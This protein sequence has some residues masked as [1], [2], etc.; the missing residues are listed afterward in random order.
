MS[1]TSTLE[2]G[3]LTFLREHGPQPTKVLSAEI[4]RLA[5]EHNR[6]KVGRG[7]CLRHLQRMENEGLLDSVRDHRNRIVWSV[8]PERKEQA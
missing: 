7:Y 1:E 6:T 3:V 2:E 4:A 5:Y 8:R